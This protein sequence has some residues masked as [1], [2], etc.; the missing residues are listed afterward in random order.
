MVVQ[1]ETAPPTKGMS[2][3]NG[4]PARYPG[5]T[6]RSNDGKFICECWERAGEKAA[7]SGVPVISHIKNGA[8]Q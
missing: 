3:V 5:D 4:M 2:S 8:D 1:R 7:L 6:Y